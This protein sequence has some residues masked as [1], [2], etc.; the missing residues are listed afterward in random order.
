MDGISMMK[1]T[2]KE[3]NP[4]V[5]VVLSSYNDFEL[6]RSAMKIGAMDYLIKLNIEEEELTAVL[7]EA[8]K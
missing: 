6:V 1:E 3:D 4:P 7:K 5:F 2:M 8:I